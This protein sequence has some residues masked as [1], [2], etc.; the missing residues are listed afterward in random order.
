[1]HYPFYQPRS[2]ADMASLFTAVPLGRLITYSAAGI[3][4]GLFPFVMTTDMVE[5]HLNT[6]DPQLAALRECPKCVFHVDQLLSRI[7][8]HWIDPE[9]ATFAD[10]LYRSATLRCTA[11][12]VDDAVALMVHLESLLEMHQGRGHHARIQP[13]EKRYANPLSRIV[14]VRLRIERTLAKFKLGQQEPEEVRLRIN[15]MLRERADPPDLETAD[16]VRDTL[17]VTGDSG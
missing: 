7:P 10:V 9:A 12:I 17:E 8:S 2:E 13:S 15:A 11:E 1:M 3:E 6:N 14:L 4:V 5:V 16:Y